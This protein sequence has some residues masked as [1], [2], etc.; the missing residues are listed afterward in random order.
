MKIYSMY[1]TEKSE[2]S[3]IDIKDKNGDVM[4]FFMLGIENERFKKTHLNATAQS[5]FKKEN[6]S[7][8]DYFEP[9][10]AFPIFS[11]KANNI[12]HDNLKSQLEA[13]KIKIR[14]EDEFI[15]AYAGRILNRKPIFERVDDYKIQ[16]RQDCQIESN[17]LIIRDISNPQFF[18]ATELFKKICMDFGL[19][20]K[21]KDFS[22]MK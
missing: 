10:M 15:D 13:Y 11:E 6:I 8:F 4:D 2:F 22:L 20:I 5:F 19:K 18:F 12:L 14:V 3:L 16:I 7:N 1:S 17:D 21:F 9:T